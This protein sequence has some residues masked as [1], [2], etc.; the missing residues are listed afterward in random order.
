ML[1]VN[2][3]EANSLSRL[4][5]AQL[6]QKLVY[7]LKQSGRKGGMQGWSLYLQW[8]TMFDKTVVVVVSILAVVILTGGSGSI[9][10]VLIVG[11]FLIHRS[12]L[13]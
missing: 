4:D 13:Y 9:L 12:T 1:Q 2:I 6:T 8:T 5:E 3:L 7:N 11:L 10:V